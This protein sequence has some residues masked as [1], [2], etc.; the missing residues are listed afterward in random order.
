[1][2]NLT[3]VNTITMADQLGL[4][5]LKSTFLVAAL[6]YFTTSQWGGCHSLGGSRS[7]CGKTDAQSGLP[8]LTFSQVEVQHPSLKSRAPF[9]TSPL[10]YD[11]PLPLHIQTQFLKAADPGK[12]IRGQL[13][14]GHALE[15]QPG[16]GSIEETF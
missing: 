13:L 10:P 7:T 8:K 6:Y 14:A 12:H 15:A 1:M 11:T 16:A 4:I 5:P 2:G 9:L 3:E